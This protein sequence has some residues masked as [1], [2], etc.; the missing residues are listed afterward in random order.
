MPS[1]VSLTAWP[2]RATN[3]LL[4]L[5]RHLREMGG[6]FT[7]LKAREGLTSYADP[8]WFKHPRARWRA[9]SRLR[10]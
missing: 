6:M 9:R 4:D 7:P 3:P 2:S 10:S 1:G 5:G 8:G